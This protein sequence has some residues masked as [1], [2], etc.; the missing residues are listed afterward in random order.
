MVNPPPQGGKPTK[1]KPTKADWWTDG[2][3]RLNGPIPD[4]HADSNNSSLT[5]EY[6]LLGHYHT[7][8]DQ[9][10]TKTIQRS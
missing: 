10:D 1:K 3:G 5:L 7:R 9:Q 6:T 4:P 8:Q 2:W